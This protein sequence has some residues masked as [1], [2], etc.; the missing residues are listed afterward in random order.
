MSDF[1]VNDRRA[2]KK[3][4]ELRDDAPEAPET[5]AGS[6]GEDVGGEQPETGSRAETG[7]AAE[8]GAEA[9][10]GASDGPDAGESPAGL[11][12]GELPAT[13]ATLVIGLA[14]MGFMQMEGEIRDGVKSK[15]DLNAAKHYIDIL[16][17][18]EKK[19]K[20]N[21]TE[22]EANLLKTF[23]YDLRMRFVEISRRA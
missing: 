9:G 5:P 21:L 4:G 8:S 23:L 18:L 20:G 15:P 2:F 14:S 16:A 12:S 17:E 10:S 11:F 22:E 6:G 3:K 1:V 7:G 19:T 13:F